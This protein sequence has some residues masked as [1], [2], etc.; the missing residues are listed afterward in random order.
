MKIELPIM[1]QGRI[2]VVDYWK[3]LG[4]NV[5]ISAA[6]S[7]T[8]SILTLAAPSL[9]FVPL[10]LGI[11]VAVASLLFGVAYVGLGVRRLHDLNLSGW[12]LF[13]PIGIWLA[14]FVL[15]NTFSLIGMIVFALVNIGFF[16][17][18]SFTPGTKSLNKYGSLTKYNSWL[19]AFFGNKNGET[20]TESIKQSSEKSKI[21][22]NAILIGALADH[23]V[24]LLVGAISIIYLIVKYR[25]PLTTE[26]LPV[27]L[28]LF[29][30]DPVLLT[31]SLILGGFADILGGYVA[32]KIAKQNYLLNAFLTSFL[33]VLLNL[34]ESDKIPFM[35]T[36]IGVIGTPIL[37]T[38]GGYIYSVRSRRKIA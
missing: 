23:I 10:L 2:G 26:T 20:N 29:F 31:M 22:V 21:S 32:A 24:S 5:V 4:I 17:Y 38:I 35:F 3:G 8:S 25:P 11:I 36:L 30:S 34:S 19:D 7:A 6:L 18:V 15:P 28:N 14:L 1:F 27:T 9:S 12:W 33:C 16:I 37:T 13:A